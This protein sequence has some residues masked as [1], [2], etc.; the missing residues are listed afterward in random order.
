MRWHNI[1]ETHIG[2]GFTAG[3]GSLRVGFQAQ[4][5]NMTQ[6]DRSSKSPRCFGNPFRTPHVTIQMHDHE[7]DDLETFKYP[8]RY[9]KGIASMN[10]SQQQK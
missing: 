4:L 2:K 7:V 5:Q 1:K 8:A 9:L 6:S 10:K 3:G